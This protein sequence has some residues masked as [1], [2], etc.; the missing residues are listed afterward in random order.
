MARISD[1]KDSSGDRCSDTDIVV[2]RKGLGQNI[3]SG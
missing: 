3:V 2:F 1:R